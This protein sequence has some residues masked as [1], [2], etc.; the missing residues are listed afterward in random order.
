MSIEASSTSRTPAHPTFADLSLESILLG[1]SGVVTLLVTNTDN[2]V[3]DAVRTGKKELA[4]TRLVGA[5]VGTI[6]K[7]Q[8]LA[9]D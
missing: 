2:A 9:D 4:S 3:G 6:C 5:L 1:A 8:N 7:E